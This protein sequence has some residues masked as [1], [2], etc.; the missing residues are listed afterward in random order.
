MHPPLAERMRPKSLDQIIGQLHI[1]GKDKPLRNLL[2]KQ[3]LDWEPRIVLK[4]GLKKTIE[5]FK[6]VV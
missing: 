4:D 2:A 1:L 6:T 5:Y 3:K